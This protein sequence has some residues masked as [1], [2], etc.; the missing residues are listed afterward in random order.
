MYKAKVFSACFLK[1]LFFL[2]LTSSLFLS[3]NRR[4]VDENRIFLDSN[5]SYA[6]GM[7]MANQLGGLGFV[8]LNIDYDAFIRGFRD[9]YDEQETRLTQERAM[10]LIHVV[11]SRLHAQYEEIQRMEA[12]MNREAGDAFRAEH[13]TQER[14]VVRPSGLQY[15]PI[16]QGTGRRPGPQDT[17]R[18]HYVGTLIDGEIFDS[19]RMR[20]EPAEFRLDM[21]IPGWTEG[22]QLMNEGGFFV[23]VIPPELAY[24]SHGT[25]GIP[26][27]STLIFQVEL[28]AIID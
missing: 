14:V 28:L 20:G 11:I 4:R 23:F 18:V 27:N 15:E 16:S 6:F 7:F 9:F 26:P 22:L 13:A 17:V 25:G 21:V 8:E 5:T 1:A 2:L 19:S 12:E 24:G 3:C 10:E